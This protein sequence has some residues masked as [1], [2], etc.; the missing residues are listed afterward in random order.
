VLISK[1]QYLEMSMRKEGASGMQRTGE[2]PAQKMQRTGEI[3][4]ARMQRTGEIPRTREDFPE[5][6]I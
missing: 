4:A 2:I 1:E 5:D 3:P 6:E